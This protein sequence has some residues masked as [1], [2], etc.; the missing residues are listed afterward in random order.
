MMMKVDKYLVCDTKTPTV[1]AI[2]GREVSLYQFDVILKF[3]KNKK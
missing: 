3:N 1:D 2:G